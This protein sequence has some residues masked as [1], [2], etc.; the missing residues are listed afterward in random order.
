M[1]LKG[2]LLVVV[3]YSIWGTGAVTKVTKARS[4]ITRWATRAVTKVT[5]G[6]GAL[7]GPVLD[8]VRRVLNVG[9]E[10]DI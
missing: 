9:E 4:R 8:T 5:K 6:A 2:L 10:A 7:A 1:H 3:D